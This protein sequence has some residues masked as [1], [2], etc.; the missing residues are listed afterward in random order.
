M[1]LRARFALLLVTSAIFP[2]RYLFPQEPTAKRPTENT[3][4]EQT[5]AEGNAKSSRRYCEVPSCVQKVLYFSNI[6]QPTELQDVVNTM[7]IIAEIPRVQP[8]PGARIIVIEGTAEQV[9]IAEK[10]AAEIDKDKRRFGG[11]G[12]RIDLKIEE[13]EG[14]KKVHTRVHSFVTEARDVVRVS[15]GRQPLAQVQNQPASE[16]KQPSDSDNARSIECRILAENDRTLEL[17]VETVFMS[18]GTHGP[19]GASLFRIRSH[20]TV[21]L[22]RSTVIGR[23]DDPDGDGSFVIELTATRI[24]DRS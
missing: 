20:V 8:V 24:K 19:A 3:A 16:T 1:A 13:S 7:R 14:N 15:I 2:G 10:L 22:D 9:A 18:D 5:A 21:E 11:L 4:P 23:V 12:Y 17:N 6:S